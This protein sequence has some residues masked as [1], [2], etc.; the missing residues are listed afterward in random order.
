M[1]GAVTCRFVLWRHQCQSPGTREGGG[2]HVRVLFRHPRLD[3]KSGLLQ[4]EKNRRN[5]HEKRQCSH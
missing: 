3:A 2:V 5:N 4:G 1:I